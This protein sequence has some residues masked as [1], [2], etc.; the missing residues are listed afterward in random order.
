[1]IENIIKEL[2]LLK[3]RGIFSEEKLTM[4]EKK[5]R[6]REFLDNY[7]FLQY[8]NLF[9]QINNAIINDEVS[10]LEKNYLVT[11]LLEC[12]DLY[13]KLKD[14]IEKFPKEVREIYCIYN[15]FKMVDVGI[16]LYLYSDI[17]AVKSVEDMLVYYMDFMEDPNNQM[18]LELCFDKVEK[19]NQKIL[20]EFQKIDC[21]GINKEELIKPDLVQQ[22]KTK[23]GNLKKGI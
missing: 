20:S 17:V 6:E 13:P 4:E 23:L 15:S 12:I 9:I 18:F 1:M 14:Y 19:A 8:E 16:E 10:I 11:L 5:K 3:N 2:I 21:N 22:F 7:S